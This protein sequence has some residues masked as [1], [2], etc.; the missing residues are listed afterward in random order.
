MMSVYL[1]QSDACKNITMDWCPQPNH[2]WLYIRL[3]IKSPPLHIKIC[4]L[5]VF[6]SSHALLTMTLEEACQVIWSYQLLGKA[7]LSIH[8]TLQERNLVPFPHLPPPLWIWWVVS[9]F[10][11]MKATPFNLQVVIMSH[12][13]ILCSCHHGSLFATTW[14]SSKIYKRI[15]HQLRCSQLGP[16]AIYWPDGPLNACFHYPRKL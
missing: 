1:L 7:G 12:S 8:W 11:K 9:I 3:D 15:P 4:T 6:S 16:E 2:L 14:N 5:C 10:S 13:K